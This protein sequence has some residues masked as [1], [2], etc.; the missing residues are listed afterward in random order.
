MIRR[1]TAAFVWAVMLIAAMLTGFTAVSYAETAET[2]ET[3]EEEGIYVSSVSLSDVYV[4][5]RTPYYV[6]V[7]EGGVTPGTGKS[8][9]SIAE[10]EVS[11]VMTKG[12]H[13]I[14]QELTSISEEGYQGEVTFPE[15][16]LW[17]IVITAADPHQAG[18]AD[19]FEMEL[20]VKEKNNETTYLWIGLMTLFAVVIIYVLFR[21]RR[22][23]R[24]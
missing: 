16:G 20:N 23:L 10:A 1:S 8:E 13:E 9:L 11:V 21:I 2:A 5:T 14:K 3:G 7:F 12:S 18:Q 6:K 24:K 4:K 17:N 15:A 22:L 19:V